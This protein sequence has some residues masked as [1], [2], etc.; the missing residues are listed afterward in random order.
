M[1]TKHAQS[2]TC[3]MGTV[4]GSGHDGQQKYT[5][6]DACKLCHLIQSALRPVF[7]CQI[8]RICCAYE[9]LRCLHVEIWQF[10]VDDDDDNDNNDNTTDYFTLCACAQGNITIT[11]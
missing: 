9:S 4:D 2:C 7:F 5:I 11:V 10:F 6:C 1:S 8:Q 3:N